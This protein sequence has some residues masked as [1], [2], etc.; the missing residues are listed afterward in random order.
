MLKRYIDKFANMAG[1]T[2]HYM[3]HPDKDAIQLSSWITVR[4]GQVIKHNYGDELNIHLLKALTNRPV[5]IYNCHFHRPKTNYLVIGSIIE[6]FSDSHSVI[7]GSGAIYGGDHPLPRKPA[8]VCAVRGPLT[9]QYLLAQGVQ[10]PEIYGDPALLCPYIWQPTAGKK[11]K[12][13]IVPHISDLANPALQALDR[14]EGVS[15][16]HVI[17]LD[18]YATPHSVID[19]I[20]QCQ[21]ILSSSLHGLILADAYGV[22]NTWIALGDKLY[23]GHFKFHDYFA[24]VGRSHA[25]PVPLTRT[26]DISRIA[27][28]TA[29]TYK[30]IHIDLAPLINSCPFDIKELEN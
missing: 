10:C 24:S 19:E 8:R 3:T 7:W 5:R 17:R 16:I 6:N 28:E 18:D 23:G 20:A 9:R 27:D 25:K 21:C 1:N 22:P 26:T 15:D 12:V 4:H 14:S 29:E 2:L 30:P 11:W 13:G